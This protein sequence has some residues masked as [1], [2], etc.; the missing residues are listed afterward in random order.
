MIAIE[1][2]ACYIPQQFESNFDK[3][4]IFLLDRDFIVNKLGVERVSRKFSDEETSDL[5]LKALERLD[6]PNLLLKEVDCIVVCTQNPDGNG[7]PHTSAILHGKLDLPERCACF[8]ISLGCSGYVYAL[9]IVNAFMESNGLKSGLIFTADPYSKIIDPG[10]RN[11]VLLFGDAASVTLLREA[12][13]HAIA[14]KAKKFLFATKGKECE[15]LNNRDG[16]LSMNGRIIFNM[17]IKDVPIQINELLEATGLRH[18]DIDL[19]LFHQGSKYMLDQLARNMNLPKEKVPINL[20][21]Q[22]NTV[23]TSLPLLLEQHMH[24]PGLRNILLCGFGVGLSWASCL[25][26]RHGE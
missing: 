16:R 26:I 24:S 23:S 22:G 19:Y 15:A 3:E 25:L 6:Q 18:R 10:D 1:K 9:S 11:T 21:N 12:S 2:V 4:D 8:D 7:I 5:C 14:W 17:A 20:A 13:E